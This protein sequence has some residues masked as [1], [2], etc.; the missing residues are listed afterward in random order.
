PEL[1][2]DISIEQERLNRYISDL[3]NQ[4]ER[5][6]E[7]EDR[8]LKERFE[9]LKNEQ[10]AEV[11][12]EDK[13]VSVQVQRKPEEVQQ[14][15]KQEVVIQKKKEEVK[16]SEKRQQ[17]QQQGKEQVQEDEDSTGDEEDY[18]TEQKLRELQREQQAKIKQQQEEQK[19]KEQ[20]L[21][22][23]EQ[24]AKQDEELK[25]LKEQEQK[26][27]QQ[28]EEQKK[29]EQQKQIAEKQQQQQQQ[30]QQE[31]E[32]QE[33][34]DSTGDEE[35]EDNTKLPKGVIHISN[36]SVRDLPKMD[37]IGKSD[38]YVMFCLGRDV[39][40][41]STAKDT[42]NYDYT[43]EQLQLVFDPI[44]RKGRQIIEIEVWDYDRAGNDDQI[45]AVNVDILPSLNQQQE[46]DLFL[47]PP[48][49]KKKDL[50]Q[51]QS[52]DHKQDS[53]QK[54]GKVKF[55]IIFIPDKEEQTEVIKE[56]KVIIRKE[57]TY[58]SQT[59]EVRQEQIQEEEDST[60]DEEDNQQQKVEQQQQIEEKG[61]GNKYEKYFEIKKKE[62]TDK[63]VEGVVTFSNIQ[64]RNIKKM[65][66]VGQPD[67]YVIFKL[68]DDQK[69]TPVA[70]NKKDHDYLNES[71]D[72]NYDPAS[73]SGKVVIQ[74]WDYDTFGKDDLIG[75][76]S[77]DVL[78]SFKRPLWV[79]LDLQPLEKKVDQ[80][81]ED[82]ILQLLNQEADQGLGKVL[83]EMEYKPHH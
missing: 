8:K 23:K 45:G 78:P 59:I 48:K 25:K 65:D 26:A 54:L 83:F 14:Q 69:K 76:A 57:V 72:L 15:K 16:Q 13:R 28:E 31:Q 40:Q 3:R 47:Q 19:K 18:Q 68:G 11:K 67:P 4:Q 81:T 79:E 63:Y 7:E 56:T 32:Q 55:S 10:T 21:K 58:S 34:E 22:E 20:E 38:P 42:L 52:D 73:I 39:E 66:L 82:D 75:V 44:K 5:F 46:I 64:V 36:I 1:E 30:Q 33:D 71:Y 53:D 9:R 80:L 24:K 43:G 51:S 29:K 60:G 6:R 62:F 17:K 70:K 61:K 35:E 12:Q 41:T 49:D 2:K 37:L 50:S 74:V 77:V 27:K